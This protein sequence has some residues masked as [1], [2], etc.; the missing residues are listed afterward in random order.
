[1]DMRACDE[2]VSLIASGQI[3]MGHAE[4]IITLPPERR[5]RYFAL[6]RQAMRIPLFS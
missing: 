6:L 5:E 3:P 4:K 2:F 1:M